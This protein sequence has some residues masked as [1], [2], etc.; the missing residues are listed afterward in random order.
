MSTKAL[1]VKDSLL[2]RKKESWDQFRQNLNGR[3]SLPSHSCVLHSPLVC[4]S[5]LSSGLNRRFLV[6]TSFLEFPQKAVLLDLAFE[7]LQGLFNVVAVYFYLQLPEFLPR[8]LK[9]PP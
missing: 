7:D 3:I 6:E 2:N 4:L 1:V 5:L 8:I 9:P